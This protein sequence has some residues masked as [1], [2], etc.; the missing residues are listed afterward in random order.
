[1]YP[2]KQ[3]SPTD[4]KPSAASL[5]ISATTS[6]PLSLHKFFRTYKNINIQLVKGSVV[7]ENTI[8]HRERDQTAN[9]SHT[10]FN[11]LTFVA[12]TVRT[13]RELARFILQKQTDNNKQRNVTNTLM[14]KLKQPSIKRIRIGSESYGSSVTPQM[15][16]L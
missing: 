16:E 8:S 6:L 5:G 11:T 15:L 9:V 1:M 2:E 10:V 7:V 13:D 14:Q 3:V 12:P 4:V